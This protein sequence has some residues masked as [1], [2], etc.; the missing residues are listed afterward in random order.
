MSLLTHDLHATQRYAEAPDAGEVRPPLAFLVLVLGTAC[1]SLAVVR[2][3][4]AP[5]FLA[6][7]LAVTLRPMVERLSLALG[8]RPHMGAFAAMLLVLLALLAP[9]TALVSYGA[10]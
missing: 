7:A 1:V 6:A 8:R 3:F 10:A 9:L 5:L 4:A 2:P